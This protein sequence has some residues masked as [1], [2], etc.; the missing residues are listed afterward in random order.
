MA[1][2]AK[3]RGF[4]S[5]LQTHQF[6][7]SRQGEDLF[8]ILLIET[9][10]ADPNKAWSSFCRALSAW[11]E[12]NAEGQEAWAQSSEDFNIG[13]YSNYEGSANLDPYLRDEGIYTTQTTIIS[14]DEASFSYD[15]VLIDI[16]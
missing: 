10:V 6:M 4:S 1:T 7:F 13:D 8:A 12:N 16:R 14:A 2:Q 15:K 11:A 9:S 5:K 3:G